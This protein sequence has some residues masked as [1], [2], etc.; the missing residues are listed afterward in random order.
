LAR[1]PAKLVLVA[2]DDALIEFEQVNLPGTFFEYPNWRRKNSLD[3]EAIAH[4]ERIATIAAE[5]R[6]RVKGEVGS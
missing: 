4:D 1:T 6:Q 3:L 2:L 5:V